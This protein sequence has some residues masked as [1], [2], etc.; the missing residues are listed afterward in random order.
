MSLVFCSCLQLT[1]TYKHIFL[2]GFGT[3][4]H[5]YKKISYQHQLAEHLVKYLHAL[6]YPD[7]KPGPFVEAPPIKDVAGSV[8]MRV[9][10]LYM[11]LKIRIIEKIE[12]SKLTNILNG[13][14]FDKLDNTLC[15]HNKQ[16]VS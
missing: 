14:N 5:D 8:T 7:A 4:Q 6:L 12:N 2:L 16:I 1:R 13:A 9:K 3:Y 11:L 10:L 15:C